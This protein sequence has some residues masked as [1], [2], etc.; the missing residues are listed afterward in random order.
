MQ[1]SS[2]CKLWCMLAEAECWLL[3]DHA[4]QEEVCCQ[5]EDFILDYDVCQLLGEISLCVCLIHNRHR[6]LCLTNLETMCSSLIWGWKDEQDQA[7]LIM[8]SGGSSPPSL[9]G[10]SNRSCRNHNPAPDETAYV[11]VW[12]QISFFFYTYVSKAARAL[13]WRYFYS[14]IFDSIRSSTFEGFP[15]RNADCAYPS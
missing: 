10:E 4:N 7:W 3:K 14:R 11:M 6:D 13:K 1:T 5:E 12:P 2:V 15:L 9:T 8:N